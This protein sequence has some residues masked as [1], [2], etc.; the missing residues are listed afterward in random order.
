VVA[1]GILLALVM[2]SVLMVAAVV[3]GVRRQDLTASRIRST[4]AFYAAEAGLNMAMRELMRSTDEDG[5]GGIGSISDDNNDANDPTL[6]GAS[7]RVRVQVAGAVVTVLSEGR[8]DGVSR[9]LSAT[10]E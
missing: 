3:A 1:I 5:D 6:C 8:A 10:L 9:E 2:L 4:R 7:V